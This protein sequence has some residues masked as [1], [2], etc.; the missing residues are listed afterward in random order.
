MLAVPG[1]LDPVTKPLSL[2]VG[3]KDSLL[4]NDT[5]G[6]IQDLLAKKTDVPHELRVSWMESGPENLR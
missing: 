4:D 2:A 6:K 1:D 3:N 5:L